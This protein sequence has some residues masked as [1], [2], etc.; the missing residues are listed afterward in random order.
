MNIALIVIAHYWWTNC[1]GAYSTSHW[2]CG[3]FLC[4]RDTEKKA[5]LDQVFRDLV[6]EAVVVRWAE[7]SY[8]QYELLN[9]FFIWSNTSFIIW[10][11]NSVLSVGCDTLVLTKCGYTLQ[12]RLYDVVLLE[13]AIPFLPSILCKSSTPEWHV[14]ESWVVIFYWYQANALLT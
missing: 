1:T 8:V 13:A 10:E 4:I 3:I 14:H 12:S 9:L 6:K 2:F 7:E 5:V 11:R